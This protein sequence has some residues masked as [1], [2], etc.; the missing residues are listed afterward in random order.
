MMNWIGRLR[1]EYLRLEEEFNLRQLREQDCEKLAACMQLT[2][3][4]IARVKDD[5]RGRVVNDNEQRVK[6]NRRDIGPS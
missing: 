3:L 1:H 6:A 2:L 4:A 5:T